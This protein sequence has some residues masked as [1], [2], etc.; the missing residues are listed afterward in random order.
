[1]RDVESPLK[2]AACARVPVREKRTT[3]VLRRLRTACGGASKREQL[4]QEAIESPSGAIGGPQTGTVPC[5]QPTRY[6]SESDVQRESA[7]SRVPARLIDTGAR[8]PRADFAGMG[9]CDHPPHIHPHTS[10]FLRRCLDAHT[11]AL[12]PVIHA[13]WSGHRR[14]RLRLW[15]I[16]SQRITKESDAI[17][18]NRAED[19]V[20]DGNERQRREYP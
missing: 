20:H 18:H 6:P 9:E 13:N 12:E 10:D 5:F 15:P 7:T 11:R 16:D 17:V 2:V 4:R 1:M 8:L 19:E 3:F 14:R